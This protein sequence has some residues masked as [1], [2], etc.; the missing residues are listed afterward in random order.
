MYDVR[1]TERSVVING[2]QVHLSREKA[3]VDELKGKEEVSQSTIKA[4]NLF[5]VT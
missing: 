5:K 4:L 3:T 1:A 2:H